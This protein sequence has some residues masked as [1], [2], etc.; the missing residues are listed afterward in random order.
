MRQFGTKS[1]PHRRQR[2]VLRAVALFEFFKGSFVVIMGV[3]ALAL[4]HKDAWL[5]A[6][7]LLALFHISTDHRSAQLFLD[8]ADSV[9]DARLWVAARIAFAYAILRFTEAYGLWKGRT[10]AEWVALVSGTLLLPVEVRE[11]IRGIT[12]FR[13]A[14]LVGNF[15]VVLYMFYVIRANRRERREAAAALR[16]ARRN[17]HQEPE[18]ESKGSGK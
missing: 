12:L 16:A 7:S 2:R 11:L 6:E 14:L 13:V 15:A 17:P 5:Y 18:L 4:V 10:W 9:T 3:C 8:F 1:D